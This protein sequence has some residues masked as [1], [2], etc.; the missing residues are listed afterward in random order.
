[1]FRKATLLTK[2]RKADDTPWLL[3]YILGLCQAEKLYIAIF[4]PM[5]QIPPIEA[6]TRAHPHRKHIVA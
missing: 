4:S 3:A 2:R 1:M 5:L 6:Q